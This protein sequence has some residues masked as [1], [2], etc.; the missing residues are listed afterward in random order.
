M[1]FINI[2]VCN[3]KSFLNIIFYHLLTV[4][5]NGI[6]KSNDSDIIIKIY[7]VIVSVHL[8]PIGILTNSATEK[9]NGTH[10]HYEVVGEMSVCSPAMCSRHQLSS[11]YDSG[12]AYRLPAVQ[13]HY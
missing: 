12:P 2:R 6:Y 4:K 8:N 5:S 9:A 10:Y 13:Q 11:G 3:M 7:A 1:Y